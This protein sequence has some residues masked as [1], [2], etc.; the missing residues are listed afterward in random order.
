MDTIG[1]SVTLWH[2]YLGGQLLVEERK[3]K[4]TSLTLLTPV[5][6]RAEKVKYENR[7]HLSRFKQNIGY[8]RIKKF[9]T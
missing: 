8:A 1:A 6:K 3:Q 7:F 9:N 2:S 4:L 5:A